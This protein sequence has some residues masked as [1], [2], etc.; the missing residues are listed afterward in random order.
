MDYLACDPM[1][2]Y[3]FFKAVWY[4]LSDLGNVQFFVYLWISVTAVAFFLNNLTTRRASMATFYVAITLVFFNI[5]LRYYWVTNLDIERMPAEIA[6]MSFLLF[7]C[8][9]GSLWS[10]LAINHSGTKQRGWAYLQAASMLEE[11]AQFIDTKVNPVDILR[12]LSGQAAKQAAIYRPV[13]DIITSHV[14]DV[15]TETSDDSVDYLPS[16]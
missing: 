12:K 6:A 13:Q 1:C 3:G 7:L 4:I 8:L 2:E 9:A 5:S 10:A 15:V 11:V 14:E 16:N